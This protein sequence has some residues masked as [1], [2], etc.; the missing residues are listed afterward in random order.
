MGKSEALWDVYQ[1]SSRNKGGKISVN[2]IKI[3]VCWQTSNKYRYKILKKKIFIYKK[4]L[5]VEIFIFVV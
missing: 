5:Y 1:K 3:M 2:F 4:D